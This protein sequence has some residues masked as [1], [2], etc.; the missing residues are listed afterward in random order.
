VKKVLTIVL[1]YV[2]S[3]REDDALKA[4]D[5]MWPAGDVSR[6]KSLIGERRR[7]GLLA[8]LACECRPAMIAIHKPTKRKKSPEDE[9]TDPR[10]K[11]IIDD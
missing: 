4:L 6:I 11:S 5:E 10:I 7:R 1:D 9:T 8:N 2:Y 3:G